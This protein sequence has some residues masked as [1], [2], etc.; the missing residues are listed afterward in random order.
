LPEIVA[1]L[2]RPLYEAFDF[3][4]PSMEMIAQELDEM[5]HHGRT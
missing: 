3:F 1:D 2:T 4:S 5:R